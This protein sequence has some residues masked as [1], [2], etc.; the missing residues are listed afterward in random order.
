MGDWADDSGDLP[1]LAAGLP[2]PKSANA[3]VNNT[4]SA[5]TAAA[6]KASGYVPPHLRNRP[7]GGAPARGGAGSFG[8][9]IGRPRETARRAMRDRDARAL[10][11]KFTRTVREGTHAD[12]RARTAIEGHV[13]RAGHLGLNPADG[14]RDAGERISRGRERREGT[15]VA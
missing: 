9:A 11:G 10:D 12:A 8:G 15:G 2:V 1:P 3:V 7:Q 6:P 4:S 14:T 5:T 13:G